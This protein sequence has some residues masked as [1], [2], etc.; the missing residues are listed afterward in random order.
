MVIALANQ[1]GYI[2]DNWYPTI[3]EAINCGMDIANGMHIKLNDI[4][5]FV[6]AAKKR[7]VLLH[8]IRHYNQKLTTATGLKRNG[9]RILSVGTDCSV[10]KM[11]SALAL[12]SEMKKQKLNA[13]FVA[14]GQAGNFYC[15]SR[16]SNRYSRC[17]FHCWSCRK[18][19]TS[20]SR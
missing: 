2:Q 17:R 15:R 12:V 7:N 4:D 14:T 8:D 16:N 18:I 19:I 5:E 13:S 20:N 10:G 1:G 3:H 11:Y 9:K 6:V